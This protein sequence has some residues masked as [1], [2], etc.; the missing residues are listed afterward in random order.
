MS[1]S[2]CVQVPSCKRCALPLQTADRVAFRSAPQISRPFSWINSR[3]SVSVPS[4]EPDTP[5]D[6][7]G[8]TQQRWHVYRRKYEHFISRDGDMTQFAETNMGLLAWDFNITDAHGQTLASINRNFAGLAR[9]LFTDTGHY[10]LRFEGVVQ[11]YQAIEPPAPR[12]LLTAPQD[13]T[14]SS[15]K[16]EL[17]RTEESS[18]GERS[19]VRARE[20]EPTPPSLPFDQR[21]VLLAT[22]VSID[23][24]YFTRDRGSGLGGFMPMPIFFPG[25]PAPEA[26]G[27]PAPTG[28]GGGAA[29]PPP[30]AAG[31]GGDTVPGYEYGDDSGSGEQ[32][33]REQTGDSS[34][35]GGSMDPDRG[36]WS[37]EVMDDP[38][39]TQ[40]TP[41][42]PGGTWSWGD[43]F[44]G[45]DD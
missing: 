42:E 16:K 11:D 12:G 30:P 36:G 18:S 17:A 22:A 21:A 7:I 34:E 32:L 26:G 3:I 38:W 39:A 29:P 27:A 5:D 1:C 10:V 13:T 9:E 14:S 45:D 15:E 4:D 25:S 40:D 37:D 43:L 2:R 41:D 28:E 8:E 19:V 33:P 6:V 35:G 24:D 44:P 20:A 23:F 31:S